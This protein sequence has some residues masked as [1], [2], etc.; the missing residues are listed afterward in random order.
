M[1]GLSLS[2]QPILADLSLTL[3]AGETVAITGPSGIGKT[4]ILRILA[5]LGTGF[6][7]TVQRS[8]R[9]AMVFQ[10]P[11]LLPWRNVRDNLCLATGVSAQ[12]AEAKLIDVGL[13]GLG[14]RFPGQLSLGQ[15]RRLSLARAFVADPQILLMDEPFVSLDEALAEEMMGL[16]EELRSGTDVAT[17]LVTHVP[18]EAERLA[19]RILRLEGRPATFR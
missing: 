13:K 18:K 9:V 16:F 4:S 15:Q 6:S 8:E 7:G 1:L 17:V 12:K 5:G 19:D 14:D 2:G 10:E 11:T 3:S